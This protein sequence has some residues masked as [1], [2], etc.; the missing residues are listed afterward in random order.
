MP[1]FGRKS[2]LLQKWCWVQGSDFFE[3]TEYEQCAWPGQKELRPTA[4]PE[5]SDNSSHI[6]PAKHKNPYHLGLL[7]QKHVAMSAE[8]NLR[9]EGKKLY[10]FSPLL[11]GGC[12]EKK[13]KKKQ[14]C[15]M[16]RREIWFLTC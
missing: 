8:S 5:M 15:Q 12:V 7:A 10:I 14:H 16:P 4:L 6:S 3:A 2:L 1:R 13:K 9:L 11:L